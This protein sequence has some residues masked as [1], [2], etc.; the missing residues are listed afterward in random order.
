MIDLKTSDLL[1]ANDIKDFSHLYFIV[2]PRVELMEM[3]AKHI[4]SMLENYK[5]NHLVLD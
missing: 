4:L 2:R 3:I 1:R 5:R